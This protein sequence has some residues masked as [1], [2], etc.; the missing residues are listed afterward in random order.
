MSAQDIS[1]QFLAHYYDKLSTDRNQLAFLYTPTSTLT[2]ETKKAQG[3]EQIMAIH[4][5]NPANVQRQLTSIDAQPTPGDGILILATGNLSIDG[6]KALKFTQV[7]FL[8]RTGGSFSI[9][10]EFMR[11]NLE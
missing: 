7:F 8:V 9:S 1:H 5:S 6:D 11:L 3:V 2:W 10:N 4:N